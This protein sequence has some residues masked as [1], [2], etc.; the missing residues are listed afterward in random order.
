MV[1]ILLLSRMNAAPRWSASS[2]NAIKSSSDNSL[3]LKAIISLSCL[4]KY[5][6]KDYLHYSEEASER[7]NLNN[8]AEVESR[9]ELVRAMPR[10]SNVSVAN[11]DKKINDIRSLGNENSLPTASRRD[12]IS[13]FRLFADNHIVKNDISVQKN[14]FFS[15]FCTKFVYLHHYY[16][17]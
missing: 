13:M 12:V 14:D 3:L 9:A 4:T 7:L 11:P 15:F 16:T 1:P 6:N 10:Y 5:C 8:V 17:S 2:S